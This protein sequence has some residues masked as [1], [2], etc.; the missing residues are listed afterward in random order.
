MKKNNILLL[1]ILW[2]VTSWAQAPQIGWQKT[3][4]SEGEDYLK[5]VKPTLDGGYI[6][7]GHSWADSSGEKSEDSRGFNDWWIVK[8]DASR[9]IVW[10]RT[11]GGN[12]D[13]YLGSLAT[14]ADS[15]YL[16]VG[17]S[18]SIVSGEKTEPARMADG[19]DIWLVKLD[20]DG[21]IEWQKAYGGDAWSGLA[22][23]G[24]DYITLSMAEEAPIDLKQTA[25]GG[26]ILSTPSGA[27]ISGEK[28]DTNRLYLDPSSPYYGFYPLFKTLYPDCWILKL[29]DTGKIE[30]QKTIGGDASDIPFS[31][32]PDPAGGYIAGAASCS[33]VSGEKADSNRSGYFDILDFS[34]TPVFD[35]WIYKLDDTGKIVW[36][37]TIGGDSSDLLN[38]VVPLPQGGYIVTGSSNSQVAGE[39]TD[40]SR[41]GFDYWVLKLD[42][43]GRI[44][45]QKTIGGADMDYLYYSTVTPDSGILLSGMTFSD[46]SGE[47][48]DTLKGF[49]DYWLVK[50]D[51]TGNIEWEKRYG[52]SNE[53]MGEAALHLHQLANGDL[54][55][56]GMSSA[57]NSADKTDDCRGD[58]DYWI[59]SLEC[60][61]DT[62]VTAND[63]TL[64]AAQ[65]GAGYKWIDC[66]T[67]QPVPNADGQ[68]F[69]PDNTGDYKLLIT[70]KGC[71]DTSACYHVEIPVGISD[72]SG[73]TSGISLYPNPATNQV[74]VRS[75]TPV[76]MVRI[77]SI[78]G[79][80]MLEYNANGLQ[81][82][83]LDLNGFATG[84]YTVQIETANGPVSRKLEIIN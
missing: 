3:L 21:A 73:N 24:L 63:I 31:I 41:G 29:D 82:I 62:S 81:E 57:A 1:L 58:H 64:T 19:L 61:V 14:T 38:A 60:T 45:W 33:N 2:S 32:Y 13:E 80:T 74:S 11:L 9:D 49:S 79:A 72:L 10:E 71:T 47:R 65:A 68:S 28:A 84:I 8:L 30:W 51:K 6:V 66:S 20:K 75:A 54:I 37:K 5:I 35:Y 59:F 7:A 70:Q 18:K 12:S 50:L 23:T 36:Q 83:S 22:L 34:A 42:D 44:E 55:A 25:G 46:V 4:G 67:G 77:V 52:G 48:K 17:A 43:T 16:I 56:G 26:Y 39:K 40:T 69:T 78:M 53:T 76:G 27:D 15:G